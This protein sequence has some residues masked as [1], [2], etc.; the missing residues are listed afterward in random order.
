MADFAERTVML[1]TERIDGFRTEQFPVATWCD[2][3]SV[4]SLADGERH[5]GHV[6]RA[7]NQWLAFD[8]TH[9]NNSGT[10]FR[11]LGCCATITA[12][13]RAVEQIF[14]NN[15]GLVPTLH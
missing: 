8:A 5:L 15:C 12:A 3:S 2:S 4:C 13:K 6:V 9:I 11:F 1:A 10:G 14:K 7:G